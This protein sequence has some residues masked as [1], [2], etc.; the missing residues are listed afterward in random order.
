MSVGADGSPEHGD[1]VSCSECGHEATVY[2]ITPV[3]D[4]HLAA[5]CP[6][7]PNKDVYLREDH[8]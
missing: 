2:E 6:N 8:D 3:N 7:C 4:R 5:Q 1:T